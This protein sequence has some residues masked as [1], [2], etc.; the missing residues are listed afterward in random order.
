M[1]EELKTRLTD[2][3][4]TALEANLPLADIKGD[5]S[6]HRLK[7]ISDEIQL[8]YNLSPI[9]SYELIDIRLNGGTTQ[10]LE[11]GMYNVTAI[12]DAYS[13]QSWNVN[14]AHIEIYL[15]GAWRNFKVD[16]DGGTNQV[17]IIYSDGINIRFANAAA[18]GTYHRLV[19]IRTL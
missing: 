11:K 12:N 13:S 2:A 18:P 14:I 6:D 5:H 15:G 9:F 3:Q 16:D 7:E 4:I 10:V 8:V 1:A 19:G 17:C